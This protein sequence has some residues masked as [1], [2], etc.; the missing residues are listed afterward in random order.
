MNDN[1]IT[2][3]GLIFFLF[4]AALIGGVYYINGQ[5]TVAQEQYDEL[6]QREANL[7]QTTQYLMDQ[8]ALYMSAFNVLDQYQIGV[9]SS[10][11]AFYAEVQQAA[12]ARMVTI[13]TTRQQGI[14]KEGV[15]SIALTLKGDYYSLMRVLADWR[16]LPITVRV[17]S[18]NIKSSRTPE[19]QGE[20]EADVTLEAIISDK[21]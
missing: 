16:R 2:I 20:V 19:T 15:G 1:K 17:S 21:K 12:Q 3:L 13:I 10:D 9:A 5:L 14:S 4:C 6:A 11:L 7:M 18:M 8:K